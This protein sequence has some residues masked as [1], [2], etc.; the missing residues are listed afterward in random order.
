MSDY[1]PS[2]V[3]YSDDLFHAREY[4]CHSPSYPP[5][6]PPQPQSNLLHGTVIPLYGCSHAFLSAA[7]VISSGTHYD[8]VY[9]ASEETAAEYLPY[10]VLE[11]AHDGIFNPGVAPDT[12]HT[13]NQFND[14]DMSM[15]IPIAPDDQPPHPSSSQL[16]P[17]ATSG[18]N[19]AT[20]GPAIQPQGT[21][22]RFQCEICWK[23]FDRPTRVDKCRN[24][25][26]GLKPY[27]CRGGC[28]LLAW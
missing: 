23:R 5:P 3:P 16:P 18:Q 21:T 28:G 14:E 27:E 15:E 7:P 24:R 25:H 11:A 20:P 19:V 1:R 2:Y 6:Q 22:H 9:D 4:S 10:A 12:L 13:K 8:L 17:P 26:Q